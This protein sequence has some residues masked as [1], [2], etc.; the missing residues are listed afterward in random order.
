MIKK[1]MCVS[2]VMIIT[3]TGTLVSV[4]LTEDYGTDNYRILKDM[5]HLSIQ[6]PEKVTLYLNIIRLRALNMVDYN[7]SF[8]FKFTVN[9]EELLLNDNSYTGKDIYFEEP[10][11]TI[12][13]PY[14]PEEIIN[15]QIQVSKKG[16]VIDNVCDI[17]PSNHPLPTGKILTLHYN[18][19]RGEWTGDDYLKDGDGYGHASGFSDTNEH[20][21]DCEIWFDIYQREQSFSNDRITYWEKINLYDLD[22]LVDYTGTDIDGDNVPIE[23][24]DKYGYNPFEWENHLEADP[25][26]DGLTNLEEWK[27][28][29]WLS[30]PF[31]QDIYIEVD[32]MMGK[33]PWSKPY[34]F[35]K[36]SQYLLCNA[37]LKHNI[38]IHID[39]GTMGEGG[40][41][42]PY[43]ASL[44]WRGLTNARDKYF[45]KYNHQNWRRG[46][47]HYALICCQIE[48]W[49]PAGGC[50]F[51]IDSFT[52]GGQYLRNWS[53]S[54]Y[55]HRS[56]YFTAFAS[57]VMHELGHTLGLGGFEGIDNEKSRFPWNKEFWEWGP[58]KSCMNYRYVY[59]LIDY[60]NGDDIQYDQND[61]DI[62]DLTRFTHLDW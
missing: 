60:S 58:Y 56:D 17:S 59:K 49:R 48:L 40:E 2:I 7:P 12:T 26:L 16:F 18:L 54:F 34:T 5:P 29:Q 46:V 45:L 30:D 42:L 51:Y 4:T 9:E 61:W 55:L 24:E 53:F 25:D 57:V 1:G 10:L 47:F 52:I 20:E 36:E 33:Y 11:A 13:I 31:A 21:N 39:D 32:G 44:S 50:A 22:P 8:Y 6:E 43:D 37:F 23:W 38:T 19:K 27:T 14:I 62:I 41:L 15:I 35:P 28:S 3:V